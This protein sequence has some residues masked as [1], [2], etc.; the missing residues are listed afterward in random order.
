MSENE[1]NNEKQ[2]K[3]KLNTKTVYA[4][5][6]VCTI[7]LGIAGGWFAAINYDGKKDMAAKKDQSEIS[8]EKSL[9]KVEK[10]IAGIDTENEKKDPEE[11]ERNQSD[12]YKEYD[13]LPKEKKEESEVVPRKENVPIEKIEKIKNEIE[14]KEDKEQ[15]KEEKIPDTY[16]LKDKI[17]VKVENQGSYG[18]CW[19]FASI[20][21]LE[22]YL[23]LNNLGNYDFS[24]LH[25]DYIE[26]NLMYG[27]R[28]L[29]QGGNFEMFQKYLIESGV[30]L[31]ET[32]PYNGDYTNDF[33]KL[34]DLKNVVNVTETVD[35]PSMLKSQNSTYNDYTEDEKKEFR[36]TVK[37]HIMNNG[38]LYAC[39]A[40]PDSG[41]KYFNAKTKSEYYTGEEILQREGRLFHAVTIVGWDDNYPKENFNKDMRP[42]N[43]GAY[44][45]LNSWGEYWG[46]NGYFY[47]SYEDKYVESDL[48]GI[49]STSLDNAI[50]ISSINNDAIKDYLR[51][52]Y[53]HLFIVKDNE[54]Y[55]TKNLLSSIHFLDLSNREMTSLEGIELFTNIWT[56]NASNNKIKD[57]SPIKELETLNNIELASNNISDISTLEDCKYKKVYYADL[58]NNN[59]KDVSYLNNML[60]EDSQLIISDNKDVKGYELLTS[61][62]Y[63]NID[64]CNIKDLSN[65]ASCENIKVLRASNNPGVTGI[66]NIPES[67]YNLSLSGCNLNNLESLKDKTKIV[68]LDV[69]DNNLTTLA[70]IKNYTRLYS[71]NVSGNSITDWSAIKEIELE[72]ENTEN[73]YLEY[74]VFELELFIFANNCNINS[75]SIFNGTK[76]RISLDL[77]DN[78]IKDASDFTDAEKVNY[79]DLSNNKDITGIDVF[80]KAYCVF[81]NDCNLTNIDEVA[82]LE[83]VESLSLENNNI[84]DVSQLSKLYNLY[85]LSLAGNKNIQGKITNQHL[86]ILNVSSCN[87]D[88][89]LD[90]S[91]LPY[92][93]FLNISDNPKIKS[94]YEIISKIKYFWIDL[95]ADEIS[96][97]DFN[98]MSSLGKDVFIRESMVNIECSVEENE[99]QINLIDNKELVR[100]IRKNIVDNGINIDNGSI[101]KNGYLLKVNDIQKGEVI[102]DFKSYNDYQYK[103]VFKDTNNINNTE[104]V[105]DDT[106]E[107]ELSSYKGIWQYYTNMPD[108]PE[109]ELCIN[110]IDNNKINFTYDVYRITGFENVNAEL[111][112]NIANF[113]INNDYSNVKGTITFENNS[114]I[115][116]ITE[117]TDEFVKPETITFTVKSENSILR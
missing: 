39:I 2:K 82:K 98:K 29:H 49:V 101:N 12:L 75:L 33:N 86:N 68:S 55:I 109:M 88:D 5:I 97:E 3:L 110:S 78:N 40:T 26:S 7:L 9:T 81:L 36:E 16:N 71:L 73:E 115:F 17:I 58:S 1:E 113:E 60:A 76:N 90:L 32:V 63:L 72:N 105:N 47:I 38:G 13:N 74:E 37:K 85:D 94:I 69:S 54:E 53:G 108:I 44:M 21:P 92:L 62:Y 112:G 59:L 20:K 14:K 87:L 103:F 45:A 11:D 43:N 77:K 96:Y 83:K 8:G 46:N 64:N 41:T 25:L 102:V 18:L 116:T 114:V 104:P 106:K 67:I 111:N 61:I 42:E 70:E 30:V 19:D 99:K 28:Q 34:S 93:N 79:I 100:E 22:T 10:K 48:A 4:I 35:F 84:S 27:Y 51:E 24:E 117:S 107:N 56:L 52:N 80:K 91:E 23:A 57:I 15:H 95:I 65:I 50:K 89:S 6:I 31:E 66:E